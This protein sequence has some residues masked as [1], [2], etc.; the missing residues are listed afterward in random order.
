MLDSATVAQM[1]TIQDPAGVGLAWHHG[2]VGQHEVW[3]HS[4]GWNGMSKWIGFSQAE[5]T[6]AVV[7]CNMTGVHGSILG[8]IA[9]ALLDMVAGNED[10]NPP[11]SGHRPMA[12]I[13]RDVLFLPETP[14]CGHRAASLLDTGGRKVSALKPGEN[15]VRSLRPGVYFVQAISR[16]PSAV[17]CRKVVVSR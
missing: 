12:S 7:L 15:D 10:R 9:P 4:G 6:G 8:A 3:N 14:G 13:V 2:F 17:N 16:E 5:N 1:T 11:V